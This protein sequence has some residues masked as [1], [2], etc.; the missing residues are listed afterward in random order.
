MLV[1]VQQG[2]IE[3]GREQLGG[4]GRWRPGEQ[5][6]EWELLEVEELDAARRLA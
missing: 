2:G 6:P 1:L 4:Q 3:G 5:V